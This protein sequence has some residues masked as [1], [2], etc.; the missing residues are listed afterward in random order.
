MPGTTAKKVY[1]KTFGCQMNV[2]DSERMSEQLATQGYSETDVLEDA[3]LVVLNTCHIREKA[4]EKVYSDLGRIRAGEDRSR[5]SRARIRSL[6]SRAVSPRPKAARS[7]AGRRSSTSWSGPQSYHRLP[8]MIARA[9]AGAPHVVDT[10]F[11]D[12]DKFASLPKRQGNGTAAAF[13]TV[14][15]GCDKFCTFCVVPYTRGMEYSR[16]RARP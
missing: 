8:D 12:E 4:A 2:Y 7:C 14:Q 6:P 10:E 9:Q 5:R 3:D 16:A 15:E 1:V 11:P 13:L